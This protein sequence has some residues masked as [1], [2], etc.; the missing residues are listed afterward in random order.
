MVGF[1]A[2]TVAENR[3]TRAIGGLCA[4]SG[5]KTPAATPGCRRVA[6]LGRQANRIRLSPPGSARLAVSRAAPAGSSAALA[7]SRVH[8]NARGGG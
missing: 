4:Q 6:T 2:L 1:D 8:R 3:S 7:Q 5:Q